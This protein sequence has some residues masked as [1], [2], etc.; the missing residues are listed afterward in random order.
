MSTIF[1]PSN[2]LAYASSKKEHKPLV[3]ERKTS[4]NEDL[5]YVL[6][7]SP[8]TS[9]SELPTSHTDVNSPNLDKQTEVSI[10]EAQEEAYRTLSSYSRLF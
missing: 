1:N 4:W 5:Q 9:H 7:S 3:C 2:Y 6:K 8:S 10:R